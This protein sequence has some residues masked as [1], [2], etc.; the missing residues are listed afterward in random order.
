LVGLFGGF[1]SRSTHPTRQ[2]NITF[3]CTRGES[4]ANILSVL[5][6]NENLESE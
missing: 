2:E 4:Q 3:N 1:R 5:E 6:I